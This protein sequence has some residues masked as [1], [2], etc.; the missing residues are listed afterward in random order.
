ES[1]SESS[2]A[3]GGAAGAGLHHLV[4]AAM[5]RI[6]SAASAIITLSPSMRELLIERGADPANVSVV[7]N[8]TDETL[9][10]PVPVTEEARRELGDRGRGLVMHAGNIGRFQNEAAAVRAAAAI[11]HT[12]PL[13]LVLVGSGLE[14]EPTRRLAAELGAG[15]VRFLGRRDPAE[16]APLYAA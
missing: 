7:L 8:W 14:E 6:Y 15:N 13:D 16:M 3:P 10:R 9:F 11:E 1:I 5:R 12:T 4:A 2:M